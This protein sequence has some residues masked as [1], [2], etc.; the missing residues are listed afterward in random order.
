MGVDQ[1][2]AGFERVGM[3]VF[4]AGIKL[5]AGASGNGALNQSI[6][7]V[8]PL[9]L[10]GG[11]GSRAELFAEVDRC[12]APAPG[13]GGAVL[14]LKAASGCRVQQAAFV[15]MHHALRQQAFA[16]RK[17][18]EQR[19]FDDMHAQTFAC[20]PCRRRCA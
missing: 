3:E 9:N 4:D 19:A 11:A 13:E 10:P 2:E 16:N 8:G 5:H 7:K 6:V 14:D 17:A 18:R 1:R 20:Q 12:V 15:E